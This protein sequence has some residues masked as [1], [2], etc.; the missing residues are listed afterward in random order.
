MTTTT[1]MMMIMIITII[2]IIITASAVPVNSLKESNNETLRCSGTPVFTRTSCLNETA[3]FAMSL[4]EAQT[5]QRITPC[6]SPQ[7][8]CLLEIPVTIQHAVLP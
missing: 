2:I 7:C 5:T 6:T 8:A 3:V 1:M 4:K